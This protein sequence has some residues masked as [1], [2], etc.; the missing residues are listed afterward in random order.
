MRTQLFT[1]AQF[2]EMAR[3]VVR[4]LGEVGYHVGHPTVKEWAL[5]A[6]CRESSAG[7]VLLDEA[8]V[9]EVRE[10]LRRQYPPRAAEAPEPSLIRPRAELRVGFGNITPKVYDHPSRTAQ[11]GNTDNFTAVVRFAQTE[12]RIVGLTLPVSRQDVPPATEQLESLVLLAGLTD[13]PLGPTDAMMPESVPFLAAM[14]EALG[15]EPGIFVGCCNCINPPLRLEWRTAE[16]M[17]QRRRYHSLSMITPMPCLGG[18]APVD[19]WGYTVQAVAEII[20]GL[21]LSI[22]IDPE[23]P[24]MGYIAST[25]TDMRSATMTS[26]SP[27]T[28][29]VDAAVVQLMEKCFGGGT[30]VGG[31]TYVSARH[32]GMQAVFECFLK[33]VGYSALVDEHALHYTGC[34]LANGSVLCVEQWL[35]DYEVMEA[36]GW[37]WATP[38]PAA[39]PGAA[40]RIAEGVLELGGSF[41]GADHT[42][43]HHRTALWDPTFFQRLTDT[44]TEREILDQCHALYRDRVASYGP[45]AQPEDVRRELQRILEEARGKLLG[46]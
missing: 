39:T 31:R 4:V 21:I 23:A 30:R 19:L 40:E 8:Q 42:V 27:Q 29:R 41:L 25:Q 14:G 5:K 20:G 18:S 22:I 15:H 12:P 17:L 24:L 34:T 33:A 46:R 10:R 28:V 44:R 36:L 35:L 11:G 37:L 6:G 38:E 43:Q 45:A 13:K 16:T 32:P 2:E 3:E 26:S 1:D 7:R 9:Q